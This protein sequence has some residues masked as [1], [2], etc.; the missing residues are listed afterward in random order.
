MSDTQDVKIQDDSAERVAF[1]L[2][3]TITFHE[4]VTKDRSYYLTLYRSCYKA[5]NGWTLK[6]I[7]ETEPTK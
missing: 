7:L 4:N 5:T 3:N 6:Q 2:M 1:D